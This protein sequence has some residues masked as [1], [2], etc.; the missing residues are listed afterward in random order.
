[1]IFWDSSALVPLL[2][3][4]PRSAHAEALITTDN[5]MVAWWG[6][7]IECASAFARLERERRLDAASARSARTL[8]AELS[9]S[10]YEIQPVPT[11]R[12]QAMRLLRVHPLRAA[13]AMQLAAAIEWS[14]AAPRGIFACYDDRLRE[15]AEREGFAVP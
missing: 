14:G 10:W 15:A 11:V 7:A 5:E 8:L 6:S 1:V 2:L 13:D 3:E 9:A 4:Q 12:E